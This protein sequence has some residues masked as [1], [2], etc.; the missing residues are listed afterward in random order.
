ME[1]LDH[2]P[3]Y[4]VSIL[5]AEEWTT[6]VHFSLSVDR[7]EFAEV[8]RRNAKCACCTDTMHIDTVARTANSTTADTC[9]EPDSTI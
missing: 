3:S 5:T 2:S 4:G 7:H 9:P 1:W 6:A 8:A